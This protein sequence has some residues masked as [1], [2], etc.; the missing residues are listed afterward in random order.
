MSLGR[1]LFLN[2]EQKIWMNWTKCSFGS[3]YKE[4]SDVLIYLSM[5][6]ISE[7]RYGYSDLYGCEDAER[8]GIKGK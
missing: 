5:K 2:I 6:G 3:K 7:R 1:I 8:D 4:F